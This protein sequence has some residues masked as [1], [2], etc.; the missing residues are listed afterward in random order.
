M[1][2]VKT[3]TRKIIYGKYVQTSRKNGCGKNVHNKHT[4]QSQGYIP[5]PQ[6]YKFP[7]ECLPL[8]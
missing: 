5:G 4:N 8:C 2:K 3:A 7:Q 1:Y 6:T